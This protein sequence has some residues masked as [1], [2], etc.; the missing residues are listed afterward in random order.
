MDGLRFDG[1]TKSLARVF[2]RRRGMRLTIAGLAALGLETHDAAAACGGPG[3]RCQN[4]GA[5]CSGFCLRRR[6]KKGKKKKPGT[7]DCSFPQELCN[8]PNDCCEAASTCGDN[9][10]DPEDVCCQGQGSDC[11][12][13][14]DCCDAYFCSFFDDTCTDCGKPLDPC[15]TIDDC[16]AGIDTCGDNGCDEYDACC[17]E[18]GASCIGSCDCCADF[19]CDERAGNTCQV[20][21][22][23]QDTLRCR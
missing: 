13:D 14:C 15:D 12:D 22:F 7:C 5:C 23:P 2:D 21:A 9:G 17:L 11:L 8:T 1:L 10:C 20:C 6:K 19:G 4:G 18:V 3:A 16:C